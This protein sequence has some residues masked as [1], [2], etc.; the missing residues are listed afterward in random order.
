MG[1]CVILQLRLERQGA[2]LH[3][4][5]RLFFC[6]A[7]HIEMELSQMMLFPC[8]IG[9]S[10]QWM[11]SACENPNKPTVGFRKGNTNICHLG[12][13]HQQAIKGLWKKGNE[14]FVNPGAIFII[15]IYLLQFML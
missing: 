5:T 1:I 8:S 9:Q 12:V 2:K 13:K 14:K 4:G 15:I 6:R 3:P 11:Q 7:A 10:G